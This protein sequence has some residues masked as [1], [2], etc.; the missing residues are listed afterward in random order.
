[1]IGGGKVLN[2]GSWGDKGILEGDLYE[3]TRGRGGGGGSWL[4]LGKLETMM[5]ENKM[6][7]ESAEGSISAA[8]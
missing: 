8:G 2:W 4:V 5:C 3:V 6:I 1:V 7:S